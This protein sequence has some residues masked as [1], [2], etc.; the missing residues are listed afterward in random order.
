[1]LEEETIVCFIARFLMKVEIFIEVPSMRYRIRHR[2]G[3]LK[4]DKSFGI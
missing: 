3:V 4:F 1:M 2:C